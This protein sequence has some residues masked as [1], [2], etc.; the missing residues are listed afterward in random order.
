M[1]KKL[2]SQLITASAL[3]AMSVVSSPL[4]AKKL[5]E[6]PSTMSMVADAVFVRPVL[7]GSTIVGTGLYAL[8]LPITLIG[9]NAEEAGHQF[10]VVPFKATF[11]RCLG[12]TKK[13]M[14]DRDE[15]YDR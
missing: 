13:H 10:V 15:Y 9:G 2:K 6:R 1:G 14:D 3:L 12:C 4:F 7:L 8:T 5:D 11:V